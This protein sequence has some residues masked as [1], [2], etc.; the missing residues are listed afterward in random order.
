MV[1]FSV[2][3]PT[4]HEQHVAVNQSSAGTYNIRINTDVFSK[5]EQRNVDGTVSGNYSY[6]DEFG[7]SHTVEY[8][9]GPEGFKATGDI[10]PV[11]PID[12]NHPVVET[13][14]VAKA[15]ASHL[16]TVLQFSTSS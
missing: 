7:K 5:V 2:A 14:E 16:A 10:I 13:E 6:K 15:R 8:T 12:A 1:T 4:E 3:K 9:A 11:A